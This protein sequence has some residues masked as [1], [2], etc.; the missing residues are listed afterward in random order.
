LEEGEEDPNAD[1]LN[2]QPDQMAFDLDEK[3]SDTLVGEYTKFPLFIEC[4]VQQ[5]LKFFDFK[6]PFSQANSH[7]I[8]MLSE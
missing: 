7:S 5:N 3:P 4:R 8:S 6:A 2:L 1:I